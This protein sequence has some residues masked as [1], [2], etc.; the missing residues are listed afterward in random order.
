[1]KILTPNLQNVLGTD[2]KQVPGSLLLGRSPARSLSWLVCLLFLPAFA[3]G[4]E[5][6]QE[7]SG[8]FA[9]SEPWVKASEEPCRKSICLNGLWQFQPVVLPDSFKEG[10]DPTP[11][12]PAPTEHWE[13]VP[14]RIPSPWNVNSYA[15]SKGLGGDFCSYPSYPKEWEKIKMGWL[16]KTVAIPNDW[17]G[18]RIQLHFSAVAGDAEI[19]I[20]GKRVDHQFNIFLPFDVD[21]THAVDLGKENTLCVGIRKPSLF[22]I[23]GK[24]GRRPYQGGSIWG[25]HIVGIW[26]DVHLVAL[27]PIRVVDAYVKPLLDKDTLE[28]VFTVHN[29]EDNEVE[30]AVGARVYPWISKAGSDHLSAPL[31]SSDLSTEAALELAPEKIRVPARGEA[32]I[33]LS[34]RVKERLKRWSPEEPNLYGLVAQASVGSSRMD[35]KYSRFG[36]RQFTMQGPHYLLNGKRLVLKGDSWHFMGIPQMTRRYAWAWYKAVRDANLNAVRLHA[37]PF[38][39]FYLD[40]ADE[41]GILILDESAIYASGG[42]PKMDSDLY[43]EDSLKHL[44]QLVLRDRNHPAIF[45][46]SVSNEMLPVITDLFHSP[47]GVKEKLV[48][49]YAKW[50]DI[51][52]KLDPTRPWI[53]ADGEKDGEGKLPTYVVHYEGSAG[54]QKAQKSGKPWGV[55][56]TGY[57]YYGTP[58]EVSETNGNRAYESFLGRMEGI[59]GSSYQSLIAQRE[60]D[61]T[62]RSVFNMVW[63]ALKPLA[64]GMKDTSRPPNLEDGIY[65]TQFHEGQTG[66]QPERLG[67]YCSTLNPGYTD[68]LPLYETWPLFDAIK[69]ACA[70]PPQP[71][72]WAK[73]KPSPPLPQA[74]AAKVSSAKVLG[75][76]G[77]TLDRDLKLTGIPI[78]SL[79]AAAAGKT[80]EIL[81]VDGANPPGSAAGPAIQEVLANKGTV[82]FWNVGPGNTGA[83]NALLPLPLDVTAR[84][85]SSLLCANPSP[86]TAGLTA[87]DLYYSE[88]VPPEVITAGLAG[89]LVDQCTVLLKACDTDWLRWNQQCEEGKT[90]MILRSERESKPS[91][92]A[93]I[94]KKIGE[95]TL[96]VTTLPS[97][98]R[99]IEHEKTVR[100]ILA[101][102]GL[103][104]GPGRNA[105]KALSNTGEI[106]QVLMCASFPVPTL[107]EGVLQHLV[108]PAQGIPIKV[109]AKIS[110]KPWKIVPMKDGKID[111]VRVP[112]SGPKQNATAYISFW[113]S[114]P[115]DLDNL[116]VRPGLPTVGLEIAADD[117]VQ[118]WLNGQEVLKNLRSGLMDQGKAKVNGLKLRQGW[119]HFLIKLIQTSGGWHWRFAGKLSCDQPDFL[120][121]LGS[122]LEKP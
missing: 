96:L 104:L 3:H 86:V 88:L 13:Q 41:M 76:Q 91:G 98:P 26:D 63:Y 54:M 11:E 68:A 115:Q 21:I 75:G 64:L 9:P 34:S 106:A 32:R 80:P 101:N 23:R 17:R 48:E 60:Y 77:S 117:A 2:K 39:T 79:T 55:G 110:E 92:V 67:P 84:S 29:D 28:A 62:Y 119:N 18:K 118:V 45:G 56:E 114:S 95:G 65:F 44:P 85:A 1:M 19:L 22:D 35:T 43:W 122:A 78:E 46:W 105:G 87:A 81:F 38:P 112:F 6:R 116:L 4:L 109:D 52:R 82:A 58:E 7:F 27:P 40:M 66:V 99:L 31:P 69:R 51:C 25:E 93:L 70:E 61:A 97:A 53:S 90:V 83:L 50:A 103:P 5:K 59:A 108:D 73:P 89:P 10:Y 107:E 49:H 42:A 36:W 33:V 100:T 121:K 16:R 102:L 72:E 47:P 12:L 14:I 111:L 113:V 74:T 120:P 8:V 24:V 15:Y 20:N 30:V 94:Q 37:Q 57:A 71:C